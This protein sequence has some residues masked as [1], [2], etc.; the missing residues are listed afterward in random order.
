MFKTERSQQSELA[1]A[2]NLGHAVNTVN[3]DGKQPHQW[4][5]AK[6][7]FGPHSKFDLTQQ[8]LPTQ[9]IEFMQKLLPMVVGPTAMFKYRKV[10]TMKIGSHIKFKPHSNLQSIILSKS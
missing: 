1:H 7:S 3:G 8:I 5:N 10:T 6:R 2:A 9:Q 4:S